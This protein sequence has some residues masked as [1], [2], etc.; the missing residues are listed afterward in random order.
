MTPQGMY[1][2]KV[3]RNSPAVALISSIAYNTQWR[4]YDG[5]A[6]TLLYSDRLI[7]TAQIHAQTGWVMVIWTRRNKTALVNQEA[8]M[9]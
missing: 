2:Y 4:R 5:I 3:V 1:V 8:A 9:V 6:V 7:L